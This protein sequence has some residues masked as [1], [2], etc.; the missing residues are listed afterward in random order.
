MQNLLIEQGLDLLLFGMGTVFV[1]LT[2]L[3]IC[4]TIMSNLINK[5]LGEEEPASDKPKITPIKAVGPA[6]VDP[7]TL[8]VIQEAIYQHRARTQP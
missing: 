2:I 6:N 7:L 1:F 8:K 5:F 3:V 4:V